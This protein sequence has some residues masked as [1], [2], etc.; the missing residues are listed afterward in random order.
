MEV[1][2][3][4]ERTKAIIYTV[5]SAILLSSGGILL[6]F[7]NMNPMAIAGARGIIATIIVWLYLKKP[8]FTFSKPQIIGGICYSLMVISF[9]ISNKLTTAANAI[10]LQYTAPIWVAILGAWLLKEK[11][12]IYDWISI[13]VVSLGMVLFFIE[14]MEGGNLA[15]N[16][17]AIFSGIV[18]AGATI[19]M[20]LQKDG[21]PVETTLLGHMITALVGLPFVFRAN[22]TLQN[23][24]GIVLLGVFQI[25]IS[26]I[27]YSLAIKHLK[28][29]ESMLIM[30]LEPIL[31][32]IWV[33][34][35]YGEKP[36]LYS[37]IGGII[38]IITIAVRGILAS[39][40]TEEI[41]E[42]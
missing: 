15:G 9:V 28:A 30:F 4:N 12:H 38:I 17:V 11:I 21:S 39:K 13:V 18:L 34:I 40:D 32:P 10:V 33:A 36:S 5:I 23:I 42:K 27:L 7:V 20:R 35:F 26:Y 8:K 37:L 31:N 2:A 14:D 41:E 29:L 22:F 6:K 3:K 1:Q 24:I 16:I 25:G 19:A